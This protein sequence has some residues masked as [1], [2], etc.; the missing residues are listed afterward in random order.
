MS[1]F[2]LTN[3]NDQEVSVKKTLIIMMVLGSSYA[4]AGDVTLET[5]S[6]H[7]PDNS[8]CNA[9]VSSGR[10]KI[11]VSLRCSGVNGTFTASKI[12]D[13]LYSYC[14]LR[15]Y[16]Y[17]FEVV[18]EQSFIAFG[19]KNGAVIGNKLLYIKD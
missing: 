9:T 14:E 6:Y 10:N 15:I 1:K 13:E 16:C 18:S 4:F 12:N 8:S 7:S 3:I 17:N 2:V 19:T 5:G 11:A